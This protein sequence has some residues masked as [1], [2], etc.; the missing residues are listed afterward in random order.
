MFHIENFRHVLS[1]TCIIFQSCL[2]KILN[3]LYY[4]NNKS[5]PKK[6]NLLTSPHQLNGACKTMLKI[7]L[8]QTESSQMINQTREW[9][10]VY[11]SPPSQYLTTIQTCYFT[12]GWS[13]PHEWCAWPSVWTPDGTQFDRRSVL[14][15]LTWPG[16]KVINVIFLTGVWMRGETGLCFCQSHLW[17][18]HVR[19]MRLFISK[20]ALHTVG[21]QLL[22]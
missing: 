9:M 21:S 3:S 4:H 11:V 5:P 1:V 20:A 10:Y 7:R 2:Q 18:C 16:F 12:P 13:F 22:L 14:F 6:S 17:L 15:G 19:V 8:A